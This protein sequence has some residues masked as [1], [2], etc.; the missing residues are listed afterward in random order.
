VL[1]GGGSWDWFDPVGAVEAFAEVVREVPN[2]K[3]Y[4]LGF[5]LASANVKPMRVAE[6]TRRRVSELGL[7]KSVIFGDWAPY[8]EREAYLVEADVALSAARDLA[9]TRLSFRTRVLDYLW[10][11]LPIVATSGDVL[12]DLVV[13]EKVGLVVPP[14]DPRA[15]AAA[16]I[17]LLTSPALR[18]ECSANATRVA[19]RF[20]W[21]SAVAPLRRLVLE[22]WKWADARALRPRHRQLTEELRGLLADRNRLN[23]AYGSGRLRGRI[24]FRDREFGSLDQY[25]A[26]LEAT[27]Q[28][29]DRRMEILRRTPAYTAFKAARRGRDWVRSRT[30]S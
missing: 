14:G 10:A 26:E 16:M 19:T 11:G 15:L 28:H 2:A 8:D 29:L 12:S 13:E 18:A 5:Q 27:V 23:G 7:D 30:G 9:E 17:R 21:P 4:F 22:P 25:V 6:L 20:T 3:L 1:W 24:L